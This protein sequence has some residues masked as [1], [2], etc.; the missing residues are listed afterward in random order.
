MLLQFQQRHRSW[1]SRSLTRSSHSRPT[2]VDSQRGHFCLLRLETDAILTSSLLSLRPASHSAGG[3]RSASL[4]V[5]LGSRNSGRCP[6]YNPVASANLRNESAETCQPLA[7]QRRQCVG[8]TETRS[9]VEDLIQPLAVRRHA[10]INGCTLFPSM[11]AS[12]RS[13]SYGAVKIPC[14]IVGSF[15]ALPTKSC[16]LKLPI[17]TT[18]LAL[19]Q[20]V[21][22]FWRQLSAV[23]EA[24]QSSGR[25]SSVMDFRTEKLRKI[26][27]GAASYRGQNAVLG[28]HFER[29]GN[30]LR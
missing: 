16:R 1:I 18:F 4:P 24:A 5:C 26:K 15:M 22:G 25:C 17:P 29:S 9:R 2:S 6:K 20:T 11:T 23:V 12:S 28:C 14:Q 7:N 13:Q 30:A 8:L 21:G 3:H 10:K 19:L 27:S